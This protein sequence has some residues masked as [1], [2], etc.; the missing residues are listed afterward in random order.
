MYEGNSNIKLIVRIYIP[1]N[2]S[3]FKNLRII[4][5]AKSIMA[6]ETNFNLTC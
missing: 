5:T 1:E 2:I 4:A 6:P 3:H